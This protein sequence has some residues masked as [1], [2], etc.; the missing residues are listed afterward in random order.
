MYPFI[1]EYEACVRKC[2]WYGSVKTMTEIIF[3]FTAKWNIF[4]RGKNHSYAY[5]YLRQNSVPGLLYITEVIA[6]IEE[7]EEGKP[8]LGVG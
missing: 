8:F 4:S 2:I 5:K 6:I 1:F 3:D 7:W